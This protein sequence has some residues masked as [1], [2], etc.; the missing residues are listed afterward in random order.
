MNVG[1]NQKDNRSGQRREFLSTSLT[2]AFSLLGGT[3][4]LGPVLNDVKKIVN[5]KSGNRISDTT[6][7]SLFA[8]DVPMYALPDVSFSREAGANESILK[9]PF[10]RIALPELETEWHERTAR[11]RAE[12]MRRGELL[13]MK[14]QFDSSTGRVVFWSQWKS[15]EAC[16]RY[17]DAVHMRSV[18]D[19]L[20]ASHRN[21][22][23]KYV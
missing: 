20:A 9:V 22:L 1:D 4:V 10:L 13:Q 5:G 23:F 14:K 6:V 2:I 7:W 8:F 18:R 3:S 12:F 21:P 19:G 17:C 11:V 16:E 15:Q